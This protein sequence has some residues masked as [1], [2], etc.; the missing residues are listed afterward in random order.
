METTYNQ[1]RFADNYQLANRIIEVSDKETLAEVA[2]VLAVHIAHYQGAL[3]KVSMEGGVRLV[4]SDTLTD[5]EVGT[6]ADGMELLV[7][8]L[9]VAAGLVDDD[10]EH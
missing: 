5:A 4:H 7:S 2:R 6:L 8:V 3:G 9:G 1:K 10:P